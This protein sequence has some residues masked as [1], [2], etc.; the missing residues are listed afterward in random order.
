[1]D[2]D[3]GLELR[4]GRVTSLPGHH[5]DAVLFSLLL[6]YLPVPEMRLR[7]CA[8]ATKVLKS[9]GLLVIV[10]PDSSHQGKNQEQL[11]RWR[12]ALASLGM[13]R[14]YYD[15]LEHLHCMAYT[16]M[17]FPPGLHEYCKGEHARYLRSKLADPEEKLESL[18]TIPQDRTTREELEREEEREKNAKEAEIFDEE[19]VAGMMDELPGVFGDGD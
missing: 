11:R 8:Q 9:G 6:E 16:K 1:M 18:M 19:E 13:A 14:A 2:R 7:A 3:A 4:D 15:K 12:A 5:Y 10:T 17:D